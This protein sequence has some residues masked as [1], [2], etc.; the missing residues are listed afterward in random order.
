[1]NYKA[2]LSIKNYHSCIDT[3]KESIM[4]YAKEYKYDI[5]SFLSIDKD[6][7]QISDYLLKHLEKDD[8]CIIHHPLILGGSITKILDNINTLSKQNIYI[9]FVEHSHLSYNQTNNQILSPIFDSIISIQKEI[10]SHRTKLGLKATKK[11]GVKLG[12][13]K[14]VKNKTRALDDFR[15]FILISLNNGISTNKILTDI[16]KQSQ[17]TLTYP[18]IKYFIESDKDLKKARDNFKSDDSLFG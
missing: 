6:N 8:I 17:N 9:I 3:Q 1:M 7:I 10:I 13:P 5:S 15:D 2:I 14:G 18:S 11:K 4:E 16:N 12:R